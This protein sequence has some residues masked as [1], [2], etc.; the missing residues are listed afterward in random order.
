MAAGALAVAVGVGPL[1]LSAS[2]ATPRTTTA[3]S[4]SG[5]YVPVTPYRLADTR[6]NSGEPYAGKT[7]GPGATLDVQVTGLGNVPAGASA[8]VL[9]VTAV[10]PTASA[11]LTVF[12]A[13]TTMPVVSNLNV[14]PGVVVANLV[15]VPL[16]STGMVSIY[17]SAGSTNVVVDV[18]GYY[19]STP[20][21]DG[22]GLYNPVSPTRVLGSLQAGQSIGAN[23]VTGVT[24]AGTSLSDGVPANAT[25]V[26]VNV[27]ASQSSA[28]SYLTVFPAGV[29]RPLASTVNFVKGET[30]ANRATVGVGTAGQIDVYN[31]AGTTD[32]DVEVD[33]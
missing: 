16:S 30:V 2:A 33:G 31:S 9:N 32:V 17:N 22:S 8:A 10:A 25:A 7:L 26:V 4:T 19:T 1:A 28:P 20:S 11:F 18:D 14:T 24:V 27:T 21:S 15:T 3:S 5:S 23:T 12:P 13:G 6:T 29:A